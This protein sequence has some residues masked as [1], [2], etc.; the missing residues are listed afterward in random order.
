MPRRP[1][2]IARVDL[3]VAETDVR[4]QFHYG[5]RTTQHRFDPQ[6]QRRDRERL[7][8]VIVG[9]ER[10]PPHDVVVRDLR[11]QHDDRLIA[12]ALADRVA[13]VEPAHARQHHVEND[14]VVL[15]AQRLR[16]SIAPI[17]RT[18]DVIAVI[19]QHID[20]AASNRG[21][22]FDHQN[23]QLLLHLG[24]LTVVLTGAM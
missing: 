2:K 17:R 6:H 13:D 19:H 11:G 22:V 18:I 7:R 12:V 9:A 5:A 4:R 20:Q 15:P 14:Q 23:A 8:H 1:D 16:E 24:R 10:Q 3:D 21:F